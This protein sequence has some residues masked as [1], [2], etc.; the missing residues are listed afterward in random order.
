MV[1]LRSPPPVNSDLYADETERSKGGLDLLGRI[2]D[3]EAAASGGV[4]LAL[5]VRLFFLLVLSATRRPCL[6]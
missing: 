6:S 5:V 3:A 1:A 4:S 2:P